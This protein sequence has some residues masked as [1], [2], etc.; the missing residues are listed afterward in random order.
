MTYNVHP[1]FVHFPIVLL[2]LYSIVK[3]LP[4]DK[5]FPRVSW[6]QIERFLLVLGFLGALAAIYTGGIARHLIQ[7]NRQLV[8]MHS[9][10]A[11]ASTWIYG[12]LL[13]LEIIAIVKS[14]YA[15]FSDGL[16]SKLLALV[17]LISISITGLLGGV[18]VYGVTAD[19]LAGIVLKLLGI[20]L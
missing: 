8:G 2:L 20:N 17:G 10:F 11:T 18:I 15:K 3:I 19:P 5:F 1:I 7:P 4:L 9:T 14:K 6:K 16:F 13:F 12:F